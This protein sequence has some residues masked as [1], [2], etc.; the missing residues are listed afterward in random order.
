MVSLGEVEGKMKR[1]VRGERRRWRRGDRQS[2][3]E[4][5]DEESNRDRW[6][7]KSDMAVR[8]GGEGW[9]IGYGGFAIGY[10]TGRYGQKGGK[11]V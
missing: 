2:N 3:K 9:R 1:G 11:R 6:Y 7:S 10:G 5:K 4:S 8:G